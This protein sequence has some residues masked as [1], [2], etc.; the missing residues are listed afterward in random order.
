[1]VWGGAEA[2]CKE[3]IIRR[4]G[5][6][7]PYRTTQGQYDTLWQN[8]SGQ[9]KIIGTTSSERCTYGCRASCSS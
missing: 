8:R 7:Y 2:H 9:S 5:P 4:T 6:L 3:H 1:M